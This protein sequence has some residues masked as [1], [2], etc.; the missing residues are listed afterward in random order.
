MEA[1]AIVVGAGAGGAAVAG[2]LL[3][4]GKRVIV[5]EA[6]PARVGQPLSHVRNDDPSKSG[7]TGFGGRLAEALVYPSKAAQAADLLADFKTVHEVGGMFGYWTCNCP[8]PHAAEL[9]P[10]I[11]KEYWTSLLQRARNVLHVSLDLGRDGVRQRRLI[12]ATRSAVGPLENGREVQAMPVAARWLDGTTRFSSIAELLAADRPGSGDII[13][14]DFICTRLLAE[15]SRAIGVEGRH[16][17]RDDMA[18]RFYADTIVV[19][20]GVAGTP[21][22]LAASNLNVGPALGRYLFDHPTIASRVVLQE[23]HSRRHSGR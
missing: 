12:D 21:K 14:S 20:A 6:G 9:A 13:R 18:A 22:I 11:A 16:S 17:A 5:L 2:E 23:L 10:G 19:A 3:R 1:D 15:G 7:L 4:A 8:T